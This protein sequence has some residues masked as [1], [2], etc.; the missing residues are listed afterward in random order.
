MYISCSSDAA[1]AHLP[2]QFL[3]R[4]IGAPL[5]HVARRFQ[6]CAV[7]AVDEYYVFALE[8]AGQERIAVRSAIIKLLTSVERRVDPAI[9]ARLDRD[10]TVTRPLEVRLS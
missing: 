3:G 7:L 9:E 1:V 8:H 10:L 6:R 5:Q 4:R 2:Y